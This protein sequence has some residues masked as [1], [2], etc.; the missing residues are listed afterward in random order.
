MVSLIIEPGKNSQ[1]INDACGVA[2][3]SRCQFETGL[4]GENSQELSS[5]SSRCDL[6]VIHSRFLPRGFV[7]EELQRFE[8]LAALT[9]PPLVFLE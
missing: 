2:E 9:G 5:F 8:A 3:R 1:T 4:A 6:C 7:S